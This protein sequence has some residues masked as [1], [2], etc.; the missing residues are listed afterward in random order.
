LRSRRWVKHLDRRAG[1]AANPV[2]HIRALN[3]LGSQILRYNS[4]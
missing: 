3:A 1:Y 4:G 2:A